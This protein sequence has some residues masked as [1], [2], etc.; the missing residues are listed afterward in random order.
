MST[1]AVYMSI[2][3]SK[4][5]SCLFQTVLAVIGMYLVVDVLLQQRL[6]DFWYSPGLQSTKYG[7]VAYELLLLGVSSLLLVSPAFLV[8]RYVNYTAGKI[9]AFL[10]LAGIGLLLICGWSF[11]GLF[12]KFI[13]V[14]AFQMILQDGDQLISFVGKM[15][16]TIDYRLLIESSLV[17]SIFFTL[18]VFNTALVSKVRLFMSTSATFVIGAAVIV[19]TLWNKP[20]ALDEE[21]VDAG[22]NHVMNRINVASFDSLKEKVG[23]FTELFD[24][25]SEFSFH[26]EWKNSIDVAELERT[27]ADWYPEALSD[28]RSADFNIVY[29]LVESLHPDMLEVFGADSAVMPTVNSLAESGY[30]LSN[31]WAQ[32]SHSNYA[33]VSALSG[34]YPLRSSSIHFYPKNPSYPKSLPYDVLETRGYKVGLFS[35]QNER[36]GLMDNY[37][38]SDSVDVFSHVGETVSVA[39]TQV[40]N[41]V[42]K[43]SN[44]SQSY[45]YKNFMYQGE[46]SN[47]ERLDGITTAIAT[48]WL[49]RQDS[50]DPVFMYF[51]YQASHSPF[52]A[53]PPDYQHKFLTDDNDLV[54]KVKEG[55]VTS[56]PKKYV[57]EAYMDSLHYVDRN[58]RKLVEKMKRLKRHENTIYIV[59][60]DTSY[61]FNGKV[62]GNGGA[63]RAEV[64]RIPVVI[65]V[66]HIG[67]QILIDAPSE[68]IDIMPTVLNLVG[69]EQHPA[70]QGVNIVDNQDM[71]RVVFSVAQTPVAHQY[72]A[73]YKDWQLLYDQ[74]TSQHTL[75]YVGRDQSQLTNS[76]LPEEKIDWLLHQLQTWKNMQLAYYGTPSIHTEYNPPRYSDSRENSRLLQTST[77]QLD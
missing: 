28:S 74:D 39:K 69:L 58:I 20:Q 60:A 10:V 40:E 5:L 3:A 17:V 15:P 14:F 24:S 4:T 67:S 66:P 9:V 62:L 31:A 45:S 54:K 65:S 59:S 63:L 26:S 61:D 44:G 36:W 50:A 41:V 13:G 32:A 12:E 8:A 18:F 11:Y 33:D 68:Q 77:D 71:E 35:S 19:S 38:M 48:D 73:V 25:L 72:S 16:S 76:I 37:L 27:D 2:S 21:I 42:S 70:S 51:N 22:A 30:V 23:P 75:N 29:V 34:Q 47:I 55:K 52:N 43:T 57:I 53:L 56:M 6:S 1:V 46:E 7:I 49:D 64:L